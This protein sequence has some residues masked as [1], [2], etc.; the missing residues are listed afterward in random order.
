MEQIESRD[1]ATLK[2][3]DTL[4]WQ[5]DRPLWRYIVGTGFIHSVTIHLGPMH[6][7][8]GDAAHATKVA[9][10]TGP[11]LLALDD[12][13]DWQGVVIYNLA[14]EYALSGKKA[15]AIQQLA[16]AFELNAGLIENSKQDTDLASLQA[17][18]AY[19]ALCA[20]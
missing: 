18:P 17:E 7:A 19:L 9:E 3:T 5:E 16:K 11:Q 10:E 2:G 4:P 15:K 20:P 8:R 1:E 12:S 6:H 13:P 14:C